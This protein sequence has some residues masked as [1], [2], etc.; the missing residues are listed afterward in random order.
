[1]T[2]SYQPKLSPDAD[3]LGRWHGGSRSQRHAHRNP[4]DGVSRIGYLHA[5]LHKRHMAELDAMQASEAG[6]MHISPAWK[7]NLIW[8]RI[9][10]ALPMLA[11]CTMLAAGISS[12]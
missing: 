8:M 12:R 4:K 3:I 9:L 1:M 11:G 10:A 6:A 7:A 5:A 2:F